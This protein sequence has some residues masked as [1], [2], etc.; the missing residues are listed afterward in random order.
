MEE[1]Q[2]AQAES[3]LHQKKSL[4]IKL[5]PVCDVEQTGQWEEGS[6]PDRNRELEGKLEKIR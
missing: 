6:P 3:R 5:V 1:K 4:K 2:S